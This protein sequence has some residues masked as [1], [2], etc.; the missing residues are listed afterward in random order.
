[1]QEGCSEERTQLL[2]ECRVEA[3]FRKTTMGQSG[4]SSRTEFQSKG[5]G[6]I[7]FTAISCAKKLKI[8][9]NAADPS[10]VR[11]QIID[12]VANLHI[13]L[14][15][16]DGPVPITVDEYNDFEEDVTR[17]SNAIRENAIVVTSRG[18]VTALKLSV[19]PCGPFR[20]QHLDGEALES[21]A[22]YPLHTPG[23]NAGRRPAAGLS[24]AP[25]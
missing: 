17:I 18:S 5:P 14:N 1:V 3:E 16:F 10:V 23:F 11:K 22:L 2:R 21:E 25:D 15:G 12:L 13:N 19:N 7:K 20:G 6:D 4:Q 8:N 9:Y 24:A